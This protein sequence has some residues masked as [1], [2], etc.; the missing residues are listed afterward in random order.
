MSDHETRMWRVALEMLA[1]KLYE[2]EMKGTRNVLA[3]HELP[4]QQRVEYRGIAYRLTYEQ[5]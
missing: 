3:W 4:K 2:M 5:E 1:I